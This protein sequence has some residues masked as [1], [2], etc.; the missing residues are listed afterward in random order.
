MI[1]VKIAK[2]EYYTE[3]EM[4][5]GSKHNNLTPSMSALIISKHVKEGI[6]LAKKYNL[7]ASI[8]ILFLSIMV[9]A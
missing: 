4:G 7:N 3:N 8:T 2:A 9:I 5:T 1:L 6:E